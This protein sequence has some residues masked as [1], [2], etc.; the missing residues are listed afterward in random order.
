[1]K[2]KNGKPSTNKHKHKQSKIIAHKQKTNKIK[3][4]TNTHIH[5]H[6]HTDTEE[7]NTP[8]HMSVLCHQPLAYDW[9]RRK[10]A[11]IGKRIVNKDGHTPLSLAA[12]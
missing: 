8:L 4:A 1:L 2:N 6:E 12:S 11:R 7:N 10:G 9:L 5:T 3:K